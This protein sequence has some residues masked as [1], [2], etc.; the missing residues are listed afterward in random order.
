MGNIVDDIRANEDTFADRPFNEVDSLALAQLSYARMPVNV[1][2]LDA[3][4]TDVDLAM[5]SVRDLLRAECYD[6]MFGKVWSPSM[7]VDLLRAMCESPRWR[8]LRVGGYVDEFDPETTKQFS[9]CVFDVGDGSSYVAFRGTDSTIVGWKEDFAMAFRR[10]VAAQES[11]ARYLADIAGRRDGPLMVGGHSKGGNLAV[12]AAANAP[13][14]VQERLIAVFC[15]DGPGFDADFFDTPGYARVAPLVDKSVPESSI[16]GMLFEMREHVE[17]GYTIVS[18]DGAS[19]MQHFALNWQVERGEF[20][21]AGGL[22]ASS[23]YLARTINGWM[24]KFDDEHRRR[25]I[26][27]LFAVGA[28]IVDRRHAVRDARACGGRLYDRLQRRRQHHAAFRV[29]LA[30]RARRVRA[31]RRPVRELPVSGA[32]DQRVDGEV[33]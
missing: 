7:N 17:D 3:E 15:H 22:S 19:I 18:S 26:E 2:R 32:H 23:R 33:R 24:A 16:V 13:A 20:V 12:Y 10:P 31:R 4:A 27:N 9:A 25:F 11:A 8:D 14:A 6:D 29:E 28:G 21:H 30:G 1:P 5:V